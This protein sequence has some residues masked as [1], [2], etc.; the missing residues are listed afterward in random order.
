MDDVGG[1][2]IDYWVLDPSAA[3][4]VGDLQIAF[5]FQCGGSG[6]HMYASSLLLQWS[7]PTL[8]VAIPRAEAGYT[9]LRFD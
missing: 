7:G 2:G 6:V 8:A 3:V 5:V 1:C 9:L 4:S